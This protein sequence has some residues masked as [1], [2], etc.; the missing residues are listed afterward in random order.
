MYTSGLIRGLVEWHL[1]SNDPRR[2]RTWECSFEAKVFPGDSLGVDIHHV[3]MRGGCNC[4]GPPS[5]E[6]PRRKQ[7]IREARSR[8]WAWICTGPVRQPAKCGTTDDTYNKQGQAIQY[9]Y[10]EE[11]THFS[12]S[13]TFRSSRGLLHETQFTQPALGLMEIA[14]VHDLRSR[15]L[16]EPRSDFAGHS[17]GEYA[18][19]VSMEDIFSIDLWAAMVFRRDSRPTPGSWRHRGELTMD[20]P[21]AQWIRNGHRTVRANDASDL[22]SRRA[23]DTYESTDFTEQDLQ[24]CIAAIAGATNGFLEVLPSLACLTGVLDDLTIDPNAVK[25]IKSPGQ[26]NE[27]IETHR[28]RIEAAAK[29]LIL[30]RGK[31]IPNLTARPFELSR[32]YF[33]MVYELTGSP[34]IENILQKWETWLE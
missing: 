12:R 6:A 2:M 13:Y 4:Y 32:E 23:N 29:P 22:I 15:G 34:R 14:Q 25:V 9:P 27:L 33:Q 30:A 3:G 28:R 20:I 21:C 11:I 8:K 16:I 17:L 31:Y 18:A 7:S 1:A 10:F 5:H 26:L 24:R 19:L